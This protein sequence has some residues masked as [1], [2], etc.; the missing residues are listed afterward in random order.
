MNHVPLN[1]IILDLSLAS[2]LPAGERGGD[3]IHAA[4]AANALACRCEEMSTR[5]LRELEYTVIPLLNLLKRDMYNPN[6]ITCKAAAYGLRSLMRS[7]LCMSR[8]LDEDGLDIIARIFDIFLGPNKINLYTVT[9]NQ[10]TVVVHLSVMYRELARFYPLKLVKIGAL[11][12]CVALLRFGDVELKTISSAILAS[13]SVDLEICSQMFGYG[14]IKPLLNA[15]DGDTTNEACMLAGLGCIVQLCRIPEIAGRM[16]QQGAMPLLEKALHRKTGYG[17]KAIREKAL[18]ALAWLTRVPEVKNVVCSSNL[19]LKGMKR[20]LRTGTLPARYTVLQMLLNLNNSP[21]FQAQQAFC[22]SVRDIVLEL[23]DI[24]PFHCRNLCIKAV[25]VLYRDD[26]SKMYLVEHGLCDSIFAIIAAKSQVL[27]EASLVLLLSLCTHADI[28]KILLS[29]RYNCHV[30]AASFLTCKDTHE[31]IIRELSIVLLKALYLYDS[32]AVDSA[33]PPEHLHMLRSTGEGEEEGDSMPV[34]YGSEYGG[35]IEEFLQR[36]IENR[37]DQHYLL[38]IFH[39]DGGE[40][41]GGIKEIEELNITEKELISYEN[42]FIELDFK[43][44]GRL[45]L[46]ELKMLMVLLGEEMD[47]EELHDILNEYDSDRSGYLDFREFIVMMKG[48]STRFG[49]GLNKVF[50]ETT[51]RGAVGKARRHLGRWR[52]KDITEAA[53]IEEAKMRRFRD[54]EDLQNMTYKYCED[55]RLELARETER[56]LREA[57]VRP[58]RFRKLPKLNA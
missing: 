40:G 6:P 29:D 9:S 34:V 45:E 10:R 16:V 24:G 51:K 50:N 36:I 7:R 53:Q 26:E 41:G 56:K 15:A 32:D 46:V 33:V 19:V 12:H 2:C 20:E 55:Q 31:D 13:F 52:N 38:E 18:Y 17:I 21:G 27:H 28:P 23:L 42:T 5:E 3:Y 48:W 57:G 37:R 25:C 44:N 1:D 11:R 30:I 39:R 43:C 4:A 35:M 49:S 58:N 47:A 14:A 8:L 22:L 54:A